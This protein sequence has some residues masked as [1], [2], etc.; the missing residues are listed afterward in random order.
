[1][2]KSTAYKKAFFVLSGALSL[3]SLLGILFYSVAVAQEL[4]KQRHIITC[5]KPKQFYA[6]TQHEDLALIAYNKE[7]KDGYGM[8][9]ISKFGKYVASHYNTKKDLVCVY[10]ISKDATFFPKPEKLPADLLQFLGI[11]TEK[12]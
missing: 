12:L 8:L 3:L 7:G 11:K 9:H 5:G 1:M 10:V 6:M 2:S 4:Q